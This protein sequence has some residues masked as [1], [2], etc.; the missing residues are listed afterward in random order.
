[1]VE[2][3]LYSEAVS[4]PTISAVANGK[5]EF[6]R[7]DVL[8]MCLPNSWYTVVARRASTS[9]PWSIEVVHK[10]D[11]Q[12]EFEFSKAA[13]TV[14]PDN[15][16]WK[17]MAD[18]TLKV[19]NRPTASEVWNLT[20]VH[21]PGESG[22]LGDAGFIIADAGSSGGYKNA[23]LA[24]MQAVLYA[25]VDE[26]GDCVV[27][28]DGTDATKAKANVRD[29][30]ITFLSALIGTI[31][32]D[33][34]NTERTFNVS[35]FVDLTAKAEARFENRFSMKQLTGTESIEV[36]NYGLGRR[37]V[38]IRTATPGMNKGYHSRLV[39]AGGAMAVPSIIMDGL[40]KSAKA[41]ATAELNVIA[42]S[43]GEAPSLTLLNAMSTIAGSA[44]NSTDIMY[45]CASDPNG[46]IEVSLDQAN[47]LNVL[48]AAAFAGL[49]GLVATGVS[50]ELERLLANSALS[51][52]FANVANLLGATT[53]AVITGY[54]SALVAAYTQGWI[55]ND[56]LFNLANHSAWISQGYKTIVAAAGAGIA[57][58]E[59]PNLL[60]YLGVSNNVL[61]TAMTAVGGA[62]TA[63]GIALG[64]ASVMA[65]CVR[66]QYWGA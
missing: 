29:L 60:S 61:A 41:G 18:L 8:V 5:L 37:E 55:S 46:V 52:L 22:T 35:G 15:L 31:L 32:A 38:A 26:S 14:N 49:G 65:K 24:Q 16:G 1:M 36:G 57:I 56:Q 4:Y 21:K 43:T 10:E 13:V 54:V 7:T 12:V 62:A 27:H 47:S 51:P 58:G 48:A 40:R 33:T 2:A 39:A 23:S 53:A 30:F 3:T 44:A 11:R 20:N 28:Y 59:I 25:R 64:M 63:S 17:S 66:H 50:T 9:D 42:K 34:T 45:I 19:H 6:D